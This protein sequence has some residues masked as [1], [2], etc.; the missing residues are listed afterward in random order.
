MYFF[1]KLLKKLLITVNYFHPLALEPIIKHSFMRF[2]YL[3]IFSS[4]FSLRGHQIIAYNFIII[5]INYNNNF[6]FVKLCYNN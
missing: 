3:F 5:K 4:V 2:F 6:F 1:K